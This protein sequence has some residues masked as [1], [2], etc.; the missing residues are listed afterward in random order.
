MP[1]SDKPLPV[2]LTLQLLAHMSFRPP[3]YFDELRSLFVFRDANNDAIASLRTQILSSG[4]S[5]YALHYVWGSPTL[6]IQ[7]A[8]TGFNGSF[9]RGDIG[10]GF[11]P[12]ERGILNA[13]FFEP[14]LFSPGGYPTESFLIPEHWVNT[15]DLFALLL[16]IIRNKTREVLN[17]PPLLRQIWDA[18]ESPALQQASFSPSQARSI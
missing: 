16:W 5:Y 17:P 13:Q 14:Y 4:G 15:S 3:R 8:F 10:D 2:G 12:V 1:H 18:L 7:P 9:F 6:G 11:C